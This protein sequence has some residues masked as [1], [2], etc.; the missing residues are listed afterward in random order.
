MDE[1][2]AGTCCSQVAQPCHKIPQER[3]GGMGKPLA[4]QLPVS[5]NTCPVRWSC[6]RAGAVE[7]LSCTSTKP[8]SLLLVMDQPHFHNLPGL[9]KQGQGSVLPGEK[10]LVEHIQSGCSR[11]NR[12]LP[13]CSSTLE[14]GREW[15]Q[16]CPC[17]SSELGRA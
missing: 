15:R 11:R 16:M 14:A 10:I 8:T 5:A 17:T 1:G 3:R 7:L 13:S 6:C 2:L 9:P 4:P 12:L